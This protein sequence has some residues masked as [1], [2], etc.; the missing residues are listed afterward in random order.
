MRRTR[1][2]RWAP[3]A[4]TLLL[5]LALMVAAA[6]L[7]LGV[8]DAQTGTVQ[9]LVPETVRS[10]GADLEWT[11]YEPASDFVKYE[12]H[13]G[14]GSYTPS[15]STL[16]ATI[17]DRGV[18]DFRDTTAA[19]GKTFVYTLVANSTSAGTR[20]VTTPS[21]GRAVTTLQPTGSAGTATFV[22]D[23]GTTSPQCANFGALD[24][25]WA[26]AEAGSRRRSLIRFDLSAVPS[27][28]T[29]SRADLA[30]WRSSESGKP[31]TVDAH[32]PR[33]GWSEGSGGGT[34]TGD[35][36]SWQGPEGN[37][38]WSQA[39]GDY[40][41]TKEA[42]I[43]IPEN[44][45]ARWE[46]FNLLALA[47]KWVDG[48]TANRGVLLKLPSD[49]TRESGR[50]VTFLSDD[51]SSSRPK[52]TLEYADGSASVGPGVSVS[53][54][55]AGPVSGSVPIAAA[56]EDD[57]RVASV[58]FRIDGSVVATDTTAPYETSWNSASVANGDRALTVRAI[59]D[60]GNATTSPAT[61]LK[62]QNSA[63]PTTRVTAPT[64]TYQDQVKADGPA[65]Y[66]RLGETSGSAAGDSSGNSRSGTFDGLYQRNRAS[67][68]TGNAD[69]AAL[70]ESLSGL[71]GRITAE[72]FGDILGS[73]LTA[74]AWISFS[75]TAATGA[76]SL[77]ISRGWDDQPGWALSLAKQSSGYQ[78]KFAHK[79]PLGSVVDT[80]AAIAPGT[81]HVAAT[82]DG[83]YIRL[84]VDGAKVAERAAASL[85]LG[86]TGKVHVGSELLKQNVTVDEVAFYDKALTDDQLRVH[87][88]VGAGQ[89]PG[90]DSTV[91]LT[92]DAADDAGVSKVEF[93][94]GDELVKTTS[95]A[96]YQATIDTL[97][98]TEPV[99]DGEYAVTTRSYDGGGQVTKSAGQPIE[100]VNTKGTKF[101]ATFSATGL[102]TA[103][104]YDP[105]AASQ[106]QAKVS[107]TVKNTSNVAWGASDVVLRARW[108]P[109]DPDPNPPAIAQ[110]ADVAL[111]SDLAPG[112]QRVLDTTV[113]APALAPGSGRTRYMLR[114]D[115]YSTS[116]SAFFR[117]KGNK[118]LDHP[119]VVDHALEDAIGL[120]RWWHY[121]SAALGAGMTHLVNVANGNSL[122]RWT[123]FSA[124][125]RGLSTVVDLTYNSNETKSDSPVGNGFSLSISSLIRFGAPLDLHA[126]NGQGNRW[127][128]V[129]DGDGTTHRFAGKTASDG[130]TYWEEP[131][132]LDLYLWK[133]GGGDA[134]RTWALTRPDGV[135]F[136]YDADGFP[137]SVQDTSGNRLT[138]TLEATPPGQDPGGP[139]KRIVRV[140]DPAGN[141]PTP[142]AGRSF[143]IEYY[144]SSDARWAHVRGKVRRITDHTGSAL[145]FDYYRDGN[146]LRLTQVGGASTDG[147]HVPDR[148]FVFTYVKSDGSG[149]ALDATQRQDP[150]MDT[151]NQSTRIYSVRDP[152]G[153]ETTFEYYAQGSNLDRWK[154]K[155]RTDRDAQTTSYAYDRTARRTTV[156]RPASRQWQFSYDTQGK[157]VELT[158]VSMAETT[159][160]VWNDERQVTTVTDPRAKVTQ[161]EHDD[162]GML[163]KQVD[164]LGHTTVLEYD[165]PG[166]DG[167]DVLGKWR[168]G[169]TVSHRS[170]LVKKTDP[171][172]VATPAAGDH[173]WRFTY[174]DATSALVDTVRDPEGNV[175]DHDYHSNG[176]LSSVDPPDPSDP[177]QAKP[178]WR[179]PNYDASGQPTEVLD[180]LG[181]RTRLGYTGDGL[182][183]AMQ[184]PR[185]PD[186]PSGTPERE[187]RTVIDYDA[188]HRPV[189]QSAPKS[190]VHDRGNAIWTATE[191]DA[192]DN[193]TATIAP[194][195][196]RGYTG[197]GSRTTLRY[198]D[199]DRRTLVTEPDT[200]ADPAGERTEMSYD[201][202]GRLR[203]VT[204]P[205]GKKGDVDHPTIYT[206]DAADRLRTESVG[207]RHRHHCYDRAGR[208]VSVTEARA[209]LS[210]YDCTTPVRPSYTTLYGWY[211]DG[212][213]ATVEDPLGRK[214][215]Y[216]YDANHNVETI[217]DP[218]GSVERRAYDQ[219]NLLVR[220][221][222]PFDTGDT[223]VSEF[224]YDTVGNMTKEIPPR[225][226][227]TAGAGTEPAHFVTEYRYDGRSQL[228][229]IKLPVG[230]D[231]AAD[232]QHY[233]H[234]A[235]DAA[236][237]LT[238][239]TQ[240]ISEA[241]RA[242]DLSDV[243]A[244]SK[245][246]STYWDPG[247]I[248]T[249]NDPAP[250]KLL[251]FDY[252]AEGWQ[253]ARRPDGGKAIRWEYYPDGMLRQQIG[254]DRQTASYKYDAEDQLV[255]ATDSIGSGGGLDRDP[256]RVTVDHSPFDQPQTIN[257]RE[258][259]E[260][261]TRFTKLSHDRNGN[262]R[263]RE[264]DGRIEGTTTTAGRVHNFDHN[265]ADE[266]I[267]HIDEGESKSSTTDDR[268]VFRTYFATGWE[269]HE[270]VQKRGSDGNFGPQL[271]TTDWTYF[272]N[273]KLRTV[274]TRNGAGE[275][276]DKRTVSYNDS[277]GV[278]V[279]GNPT[280][281]LL[282]IVGPDA[283]K[284]CHSATSTCKVAYIYDGRDRLKREE[285]TFGSGTRTLTYGLDG[286]GNT[287]SFADSAGQQPGWTAKY[288]GNRIT[289][290]TIG[291]STQH[292]RYDGDGNLSCVMAT[293]TASCPSWSGGS[294]PA[295]A[296]ESYRRDAL[297]RPI[298]YA[299]WGRTRETSFEYDA[300]DRP[301]QQTSKK[302]GTQRST[303][304]TYI[305]LTQQV[306]SEQV[307]S[308]ASESGS[309][310]KTRTY[311]YDD[312][313][314]RTS[315]TSQAAGGSAERFVFGSDAR[316]SVSV[317]MDESGQAKEAYGYTAHGDR[318]T[319]LT[320]TTVD[321]TQETTSPF[322]ELNPY[323][324]E[325][326]RQDEA[327]QTLDMGARRFSP[328]LAA[329]PEQ[330]AYDDALANLSLATDPLT[331]N[332]Y[333]F[334]GGNPVSFVESDGHEPSSSYTDRR[335]VN[336]YYSRR[337]ARV[338][339]LGRYAS[340]DAYDRNRRPAW[341]RQVDYS[342]R[343]ATIRG[344][345]QR[346]QQRQQEEQSGGASGL[347]HGALDVAGLV[348]VVG[349]P[350]DLVNAAL[351]KAEGRDT[352]AA[353]SAAG[354]I[355]IVGWGATA[356]KAA[357]KLEKATDAADA[358]RAGW[359]RGDDI[360]AP[361]RAGNTPARSTVRGRYWKNAAETPDAAERYGADNLE[362][363]RRGLAP[364]RAN[365]NARGGRES[366][367]LSHEPVPA[368]SGGQELRE[369]W[370][371][372]HAA[373]DPYRNPG[374]C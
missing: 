261:L 282:R 20:T 130:S 148:A 49:E 134:N 119:V 83:A 173:E 30:L 4:G 332:R 89:P 333:A 322:E 300:L 195:Y 180:P 144:D 301:V 26:S 204:E 75:D 170:R 295:N 351:Y 3:I 71:G 323:R 32:H 278:Y 312:A 11:A 107:V 82:Y 172:G 268:R 60:A 149:P 162:N 67:L 302:N 263:V 1:T 8:A 178:P 362:R 313:G 324:W 196:G 277:G 153:R 100:I 350:A 208:L 159:T 190:T 202:A 132:G 99:Y 344:T 73:R 91:T 242:A 359:E 158:N 345:H 102:P 57:G 326:K 218:A 54:P 12:V 201:A 197:A 23:A 143:G 147:N 179:Y 35:G 252:H 93:Y 334:A 74:E 175:T 38:R 262:V 118:P 330:D 141:D 203:Q 247:W 80:A 156:T 299:S 61:T 349:E 321:E 353:L 62:V 15:A 281:E 226:R 237:N 56:A 304:L 331:Q 5:P 78:L 131:A 206:Y 164:P 101:R 271:R 129:T 52:L 292:Y 34:C 31:E 116:S 297:G 146:L 183:R 24:S 113:Q 338:R 117:D 267:E 36:A 227:E 222:E 185:H 355:P 339:P 273:G 374:Y 105:N 70:L 250:N 229:R 171:K 370:P 64:S 136:H 124:R 86:T 200:S 210:T 66:W 253:A 224:R 122:V 169:R 21:A 328:K 135:T 325:G 329:F 335:S 109:L 207:D 69:P 337:R 248:R 84:F 13:R 314:R 43:S 315:M 94:V 165:H 258:L 19:P 90:Y 235:Y 65:A 137:T 306:A 128:G 53:R 291:G 270:A 166:V 160:V 240:P 346:V 369:R 51:A 310:V 97:S 76:E 161:Y 189:R 234:R 256:V 17:R 142:I 243:P 327:T 303:F 205:R 219:R 348:P 266:L 9:L 217:T 298:E 191:Y 283:T 280:E 2:Y 114:L 249:T 48:T 311:S 167:N 358:Q 192:N 245:T 108:Q 288:A 96:P 133:P 305:A 264:D 37:L 152:R 40:A 6:G 360:W 33:R 95:A 352:E 123:P 232:K 42:S 55:G 39:G 215:L 368:R 373:V 275:V 284:P 366:L 79:S 199:M 151:A 354:A 225:A 316:G 289:E 213:L 98:P 319:Q 307:R 211:D 231:E 18:T 341:Q 14:T 104:L 342:Y 29:L 193:V 293:S 309:L 254:R 361:T 7:R 28:S 233:V 120:E 216:T 154:L 44:A 10:N 272:L 181:H 356:G 81:H 367:E 188:F 287:T 115:M 241:D 46:T 174:I 228:T 290:R 72:T 121:D 246:T 296:I 50:Y 223:V 77:L 220:R 87:G 140:T 85:A 318:D 221:E 236:G 168:A 126:V 186:E 127:V 244:A 27:G 371:C 336:R 125:G 47:Q 357:Y 260:Q 364:Q 274:E 103:L 276:R 176:N 238:A 25:L 251:R 177:A 259:D 59:D 294:A 68:L 63:P 184:D 285:R 209:Q 88:D 257:V 138:F 22:E 308:G 239:T 214:T 155:S 110:P 187:Y 111:G 340:P 163:T 363:M 230:P 279:N 139:K 265:Q 41:G 317:L 343:A 45:A 286:A 145:A 58:E 150:P 269:K 194:H 106:E 320:K 212:Q 365:P 347:V 198:D 157:P 182:L 16:L 112:A 255:Q 372:E 92:A